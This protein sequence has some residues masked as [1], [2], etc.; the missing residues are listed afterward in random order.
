MIVE[1]EQHVAAVAA[2]IDVFGPWREHQRVDRQVG[3][4]EAPIGLRLQHVQLHRR[5]RHAQVQPRRKRVGDDV[6]VT[7]EDQLPDDLLGPGGARLGVAGDHHVVVTKGELVPDGGIHV[8]VRQL[9]RLARHG[10]C[11]LRHVTPERSGWANVAPETRAQSV[12][13][14]PHRPTLPPNDRG[15]GA[16]IAPGSR[17]GFGRSVRRR[18]RALGC[19]RPRSSS[20]PPCRSRRRP[21]CKSFRRPSGRGSW[22]AA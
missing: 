16:P 6:L 5:R 18:S 4:D 9:A 21:G 8:V 22:R 19:G 10:G 2:H 1:R 7:L 13:L 11:I 12:A 20:G 17:S 15:W 14:I 3:L